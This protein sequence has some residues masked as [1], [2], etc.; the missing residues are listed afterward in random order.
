MSIR[1]IGRA[2]ISV[3][4]ELYDRVDVVTLYAVLTRARTVPGVPRDDGGLRNSFFPALF[5]RI[6]NSVRRRRSAPTYR[7]GDRP[8]LTPGESVCRKIGEGRTIRFCFLN[9]R[10]GVESSSVTE[11]RV[12]TDNPGIRVSGRVCAICA[13]R[14]GS[15]TRLLIISTKLQ[16]F[17]DGL[18]T[19]T[20]YGTTTPVKP[21]FRNITTRGLRSTRYRIRRQCA[22]SLG[23]TQHNNKL[24]W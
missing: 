6:T 1:T 24:A 2:L 10:P 22:Y 20:T 13:K 3:I 21:K 4:S 7:S 14:P 23:R 16:H 8:N 12:N 17:Q 11:R 5:S 15:S 19:F 9:W 18:L